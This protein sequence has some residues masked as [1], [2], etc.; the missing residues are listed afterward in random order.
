MTWRVAYCII[1]G[2]SQLLNQ[3]F[4]FEGTHRIAPTHHWFYQY[5]KHYWTGTYR[6]L[7]RQSK[8]KTISDL[9]YYIIEPLVGANDI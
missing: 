4:G 3:S 2:N 6:L 1:Q 5:R 9:G 7:N 8:I